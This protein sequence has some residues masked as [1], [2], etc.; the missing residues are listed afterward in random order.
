[1]DPY[2]IAPKKD[3]EAI[4]AIAENSLTICLVEKDFGLQRK[5]GRICTGVVQRLDCLPART[6]GHSAIV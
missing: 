6:S 2:I 3:S 5:Q 1:M 4:L